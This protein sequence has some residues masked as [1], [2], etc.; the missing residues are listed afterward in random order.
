MSKREEWA[1]LVS[2][3]IIITVT[4]IGALLGSLFNKGPKKKK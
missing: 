4:V 1:D 3:G 2:L